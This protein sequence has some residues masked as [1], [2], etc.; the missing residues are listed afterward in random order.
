MEM[1]QIGEIVITLLKAAIEII[2]TCTGKTD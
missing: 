2:E 1:K